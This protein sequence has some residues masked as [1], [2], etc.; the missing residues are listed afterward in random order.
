MSPTA[1]FDLI[2]QQQRQWIRRGLILLLTLSGFAL[3]LLNT[4][5]QTTERL[6]GKIA[7]EDHCIHTL[8]ASEHLMLD[9]RR[10]EASARGYALTHLPDFKKQFNQA[11]SA[12]KTHLILWLNASNQVQQGK[13]T[14]SRMLDLFTKRQQ[15]LRLWFQP[16]LEYNQVML[17][18]SGMAQSDSLEALNQQLTHTLQQRHNQLSREIQQQLHAAVI[19]FVAFAALF[20]L[21]LIVFFFYLLASLRRDWKQSAE[22]QQQSM[23]DELTGLANRRQF[24]QQAERLIKRMERTH[25][26][27]ALL[28]LDLDGFKHIN[29]HYGHDTGDQV[30]RDVAQ[31]LRQQVRPYDTIARIGGDEFAMLVSDPIDNPSLE[32]LAQRIIQKIEQGPYQPLSASIGIARYP[33]HAHSANTLQHA[34]DQAMYLAKKKGKHSY[35]WADSR[36]HQ[37]S[38]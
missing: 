26:T 35:C 6:L 36:Q 3:A 7:E 10:M 1:D 4:V 33:D 28:Y 32:R 30:L 2:H 21:I 20:F 29:D 22:W 38:L 5:V 11:E 34:A 27:M 9:V 25:E 31:A 12:S 13:K 23:I 16:A 19:S 24:Q 17:I 15:Q 14:Q 8:E 18:K 37:T